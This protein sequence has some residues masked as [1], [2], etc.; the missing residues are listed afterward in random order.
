MSAPSPELV[1]AAPS[2]IAAIRIFQQFETDMGTNPLLW[3]GNYL[4]AK[5]KAVG[6]LGLLL[7]GLA[8]AEAGA[9][10]NLINVQGNAWIAELTAIQVPVVPST[11]P[12]PTG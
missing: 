7:P 5:T 2:L 12:A 8:T 10:Q 3:P 6:S 4:P 1:A 9:L 11:R